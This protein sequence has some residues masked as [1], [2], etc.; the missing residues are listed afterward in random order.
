MA[1]Q[2]QPV[3]EYRPYTL[4]VEFPVL[5]LTGE[6]WHIS[7]QKS[8]RLHFHNCL[9]LGICHSESG[10]MEF[11]GRPLEF[12]AGDIVCVPKNLPHTT[13]STKGCASLWSYIFIDTD[14]L[15]WNVPPL[16]P[17][18]SRLSMAD[19]PNFQYILHKND[20]PK[21][22]LLVQYTFEELR[23]QPPQYELSVRSLIFSL[24]LEMIRIQD[25]QQENTDPTDTK[26]ITTSESTLM[27]APA[28]DFI[29]KNYMNQFTIDQLAD[30][31]HLSE[32]HFRRVFLQTM[33]TAPLEFVNHTRIN[34]ACVLLK[35]TQE[36]IL[37]I[38]EQ[39]GFHTISSFNRCFSKAMG[40]APRE[41]RKQILFSEGKSEQG[42]ISIIEEYKGWL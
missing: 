33:G 7:D 26:T 3:T 17:L 27:I 15:F 5:L 25:K 32:T 22:A 40:S 31:C 13:Y 41:W 11:E 42:A 19:F 28:L 12:H 2:K 9:E 38:S 34:K 30:L 35:T 21:L 14:N 4:P 37:Y 1:K 24:L 39:V 36:S 18:L 29:E 23:D 8:G 20:Y 10:I 16:R 6:R